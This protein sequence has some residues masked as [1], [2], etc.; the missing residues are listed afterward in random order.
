MGRRPVDQLGGL[1]LAG[2]VDR[3][4]CKQADEQAN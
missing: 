1:D 2:V 3:L 4:V